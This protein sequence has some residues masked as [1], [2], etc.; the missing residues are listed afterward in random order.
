[1]VAGIRKTVRDPWVCTNYQQEIA[2]VHILGGV[3]GLAAEH[4]TVDPEIP[5]FLLRQCVEDIARTK[6]AQECI[7]IGAAGVVALAATAIERHA[8]AAVPVDQASHP[9]GDFG[10]RDIP[11]DR[12][13]PAVGATPQRRGEPVLVVR[14]IRDAR[15]F[16][17][18]IA[19][20]FRAGAIAPDLLDTPVIDQDFDPAIDIT[21]I[22]GGLVPYA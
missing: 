17:A 1:M 14:I 22:A 21:E 9:R 5:G 10:N 8:L 11:F 15:G 20:R 19:L 7:G 12:V 2:A 3:T 16:I 6:R 18:K 4:V 13:E